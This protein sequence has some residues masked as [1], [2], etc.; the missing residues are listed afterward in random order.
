VS[1]ETG[2]KKGPEAIIRA[3]YEL[4]YYDLEYDFNVTKLKY[5][6]MQPIGFDQIQQT[7]LKIFNDGKF[8]LSVGGDHSISIPILEIIPDSVSI[9]HFD[10]H[11]DMREEYMGNKLSHGSALYSAS[12]NHRVVHTGIRSGCEEDIENA[13]KFGNLIVNPKDITGILD[14]LNDEVYITFDVDFLDPSIMAATGTPE[15]NGFL[16]TDADKILRETFTNK[17]VIGIDYVELSPRAGMHSCDS[18]IAKLMM[19]TLIY[20]TL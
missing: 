15:P 11:L 17:N 8:P 20:N 18:A 9:L 2:T 4:E 5:H 10:A 19:R 1:W 13:R 7:L 12:K 14:G 3:S 16:W 6:T